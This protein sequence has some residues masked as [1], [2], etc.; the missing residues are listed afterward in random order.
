MKRILLVLTAMGAFAAQADWLYFLVNS[1]SA[2]GTKYNFDYAMVGVAQ[3]GD[4]GWTAGVDYLYAVNP[5]SGAVT[6]ATLF[7]SRPDGDSPYVETGEVYANIRDEYKSDSYAFYVET[8]KVGGEAPLW[9]FDGATMLGYEELR[10]LG[11]VQL[12]D[13]EGQKLGS[14]ATAWAVPEPTGGTLLL[15]GFAALAL[16][17]RRRVEG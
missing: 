2:E 6:D 15:L 14:T 17:R 16:R 12:T 9:G 4:G 1:Y 5:E 11:H 3:K 8:W 10:E 7:E 13:A